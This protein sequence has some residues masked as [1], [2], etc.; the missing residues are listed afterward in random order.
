MGESV[1]TCTSLAPAGVH[2]DHHFSQNQRLLLERAIALIICASICVMA[3]GLFPRH[4]SAPPA[5]YAV[6]SAAPIA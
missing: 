3:L 6:A 5:G 4:T 1:Q 2:K